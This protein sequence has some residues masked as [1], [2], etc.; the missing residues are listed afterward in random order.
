MH[1]PNAESPGDAG[2]GKAVVVVGRFEL[3]VGKPVGAAISFATGT[4]ERQEQRAL[5]R[6][7]AARDRGAREAFGRRSALEVGE[8]IVDDA[9]GATASAERAEEI[10]RSISQGGID[11]TSF[12]DEIER[13][14]DFLQRLDRS[15]RFDEALRLAKSL[16]KALA[17]AKRWL[18]L[19][20][21]LRAA[22]HAAEQVDDR[23][24]QA[25][26]LHELGTLHLAGRRTAEA[27][28]LLSRAREIRER[29]GDQQALAATERN[30]GVLC[31]TLRQLLA[32]G[33]VRSMLASAA[34]HP[35][36][37]AF[38]LLFVLGV[39]GAAGAAI[40]GHLDDG[41]GTVQVPPRT[42]LLTVGLKGKGAGRVSSRPAAI[43]C[44]RQCRGLFPE[45]GRVTLEASASAGSTFVRWG[46]DCQGNGE[47]VVPLRG[48]RN[49]TAEF[50][51]GKPRLQTLSVRFE[52]VGT[53]KSDPPQVDCSKTCDVAVPSGTSIVLTASTSEESTFLGWDDDCSGVHKCELTID[54]PRSV[55]ARFGT[56]SRLQTLT[57]NREGRGT[58]AVISKPS[59][60]E[61]GG[62]CTFAY[63]FGTRVTLLA[64]ADTGSR[65]GRWDGCTVTGP[66]CSVLMD[67]PRSV[68]ATFE[69]VATL[70]IRVLQSKYGSVVASGL[71]PASCS[72]GCTV[73]LGRT[74]KL[75]ARHLE[76]FVPSWTIRDADGAVVDAAPAAA[77]RDTCGLT[78]SG[79]R[80]VT[81]SFARSSPT[82][83]TTTAPG[84]PP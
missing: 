45:G 65:L 78:M 37:V 1:K 44:P 24:A 26:A 46:G 7:L 39:G 56:D 68:T 38:G 17:L 41:D 71:D 58:G 81:V 18:A 66:A 52:G 27:D 51:R 32:H 28:R 67:Q 80:L 79:D 60:I 9:S 35:V 11:P 42:A 40:R 48:S 53:V 22:L 69:R 2:S 82:T 19:I 76:G 4:E 61:C 20:R 72:P 15:G 75:S 57:V 47:C 3:D 12:T 33:A 63:A 8:G 30:L 73:T 6:A 74:V 36:L 23:E 16:S 84:V 10:F 62:T 14:V 50:A 21:S 49:V 64:R 70:T 55:T 13:L 25:W 29:L 31:Q 5:R 34:R 43:D 59:G 54:G 83:T 77:C